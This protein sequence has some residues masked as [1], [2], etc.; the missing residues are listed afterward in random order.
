[1]AVQGY[2]CERIF[3]YHC[4]GTH[5]IEIALWEASF[6][7]LKTTMVRKTKWMSYVLRRCY[8][9]THAFH[10]LILVVEDILL[11]LHCYCVEGWGRGDWSNA[12]TNRGR[13]ACIIIWKE[14]QGCNQ[15][16]TRKDSPKQNITP[17]QLEASICDSEIVFYIWERPKFL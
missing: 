14:R 10:W 7:F 8:P 3:S 15:S 5:V 16:I 17:L 12:I 11:N 13:R 2:I 1:M 4:W 9:T 6:V